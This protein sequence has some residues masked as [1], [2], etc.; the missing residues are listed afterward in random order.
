MEYLKEEREKKENCGGIFDCLI[1]QLNPGVTIY[2]YIKYKH[3][4]Q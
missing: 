3:M 2:S 4:I 1:Y